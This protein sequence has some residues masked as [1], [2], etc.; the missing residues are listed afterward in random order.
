MVY[1][2]VSFNTTAMSLGTVPE[3]AKGKVLSLQIDDTTAGAK[4]LY[5]HDV[6]TPSVSNGVAVPVATTKT[7][8]QLTIPG[9]VPY[10]FS[11]S[12]LAGIELFGA[13]DVSCNQAAAGSN[14]GVNLKYV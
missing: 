4:T 7:W 14:I 9:S 5:F 12:D 11:E 6:F 10:N 1:K 13:L 2:D 8:F 3:H